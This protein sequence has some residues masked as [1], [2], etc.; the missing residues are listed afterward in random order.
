MSFVLPCSLVFGTPVSNA[1]DLTAR[2]VTEAFYKAAP[3]HAPDLSGKDLS[4]LDLSNI[5]FKGASLSHADFYGTDLTHSNLK[6]TN[7][8][9]VRFERS[10][11]QSTFQVSTWKEPQ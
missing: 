2:Q 11:Y 7:M 9:G 8:S 6:G 3:G 4:F 1:A 5:D 10:C